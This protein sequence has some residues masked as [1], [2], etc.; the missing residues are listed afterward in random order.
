MH[1]ILLYSNLLF[2]VLLYIPVAFPDLE[3]SAANLTFKSFFKIRFSCFF[4][5]FNYRCWQFS[6]CYIQSF[7]WYRLRLSISPCWLISSNISR[8]LFYWV[9]SNLYNLT[10]LQVTQKWLSWT[11]VHLIKHLYKTISNQ[12]KLFLAG[13]WFLFLLPTFYKQQRYAR[14][15]ISNFVYLGTILE[16]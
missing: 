6:L 12:I 4:F 16:N 1:S 5:V 8:L 10:T 11:G 3:G 14:I 7:Y 2:H 15:K 9:Q 13:F